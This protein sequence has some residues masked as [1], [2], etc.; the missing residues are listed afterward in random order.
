MV[1]EVTETAALSNVE[2]SQRTVEEMAELGVRFALDDFGTGFSSFSYLA[3]LRPDLIKIDRS[4]VGG[5]GRS[6]YD[7]GL[8]EAMV[9]LGHGLGITVLAEGIETEEQ[10]ARLR[11]LCCE[12]AQGYLFARPMPPADI[13]AWLEAVATD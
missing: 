8:L 10:A 12:L 13:P 1:L 11:D 4:F 7:D 6:S 3:L 9:A 5:V 2:S